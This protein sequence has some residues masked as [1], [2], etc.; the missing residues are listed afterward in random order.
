MLLA[1]VSTQVV[2]PFEKG[3]L[4]GI[5]YKI[6]IHLLN[7]IKKNDLLKILPNPPFSKEGTCVDTNA[8]SMRGMTYS[9]RSTSKLRCVGK[10]SQ[11]IT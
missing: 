1:L 3:R 8:R 11:R 4:G 9:G 5:L 7:N 6:I 2:P 10:F